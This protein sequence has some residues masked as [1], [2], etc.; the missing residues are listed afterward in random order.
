MCLH[1]PHMSQSHSIHIKLK[2]KTWLKKGSIVYCGDFEFWLIAH[3]LKIV[4]Y[5]GFTTHT[6]MY[7]VQIMTLVIVLKGFNEWKIWVIKVL[8]FSFDFLGGELLVVVD[9]TKTLD[10]TKDPWKNWT[11]PNR[12]QLVVQVAIPFFC[13]ESK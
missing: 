6:P 5:D 12:L 9:D 10:G 7:T 13:K 8:P 2:I 11:I 1:C 3:K 4:T